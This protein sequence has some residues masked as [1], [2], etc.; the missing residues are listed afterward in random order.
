MADEDPRPTGKLVKNLDI[1]GYLF[2]WDECS[3]QPVLMRSPAG[4]RF[5]LPIFSSEQ[6]LRDAME[7]ICPATPTR[8]K[9][10]LETR[11]FLES[12]EAAGDVVVGADPYIH[13][14][15]TRWLQVTSVV[16]A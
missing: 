7:W 8:I 5:I 3:D 9:C 2:P 6:K 13:N 11:E 4:G 16:I 10:I 1:A 15:N 12:I 14:G